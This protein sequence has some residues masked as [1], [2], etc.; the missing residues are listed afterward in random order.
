ME[1]KCVWASSSKKMDQVKGRQGKKRRRSKQASN[2]DEAFKT[3]N[4]I[5]KTLGF[6]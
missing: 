6:W 3:L 5:P 2:A 4:L 1:P